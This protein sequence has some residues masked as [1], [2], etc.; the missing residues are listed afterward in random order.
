MGVLI[1]LAC[2]KEPS[3]GRLVEHTAPASSGRKTDVGARMQMVCSPGV[4]ELPLL[5]HTL[6][7]STHHGASCT[8]DRLLDGCMGLHTKSI[9]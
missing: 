4:G 3:A 8:L 5:T 7:A 9:M 6:P 1:R 2:V